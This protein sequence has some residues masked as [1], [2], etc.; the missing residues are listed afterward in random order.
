MHYRTAELQMLAMDG[1][2]STHDASTA[3]PTRGLEAP[4][5]VAIGVAVRPDARRCHNSSL[6]KG[7]RNSDRP[8]VR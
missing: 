7:L 6:R 8:P 2:G 4:V 1:F 5:G 3:Q